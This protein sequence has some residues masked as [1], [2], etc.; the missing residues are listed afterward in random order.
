[1]QQ[2]AGAHAPF[3]EDGR[4]LDHGVD[5][6]ARVEEG[7]ALREHGQQDDAGGPDVDLARLR[8]ALEQD[9]GG[10]EAAG[11]GAVGA[12]RGPGVILGVGGHGGVLGRVRVFD[13]QA[14]PRGRLGADAV[15]SVGALALRKTEVDEHAPLAV[16]VIQEVGRLDVPVHD[17][18]P[19]HGVEGGEEGGEVGLHVPG[20]HPAEVLAE[21]LV[22]VVGEDGDD[23]VLVAEGGNEGAY[24]A[25]V[26]KVVEEL[27]LV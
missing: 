24:R 20:V 10:A 8:G 2:G 5:V 6:V 7:E 25:G 15:G 13:L 23:L 14:A 11:A 27:E 22:L 16:D 3:A 18:F 21:V 12:A 19:V 9:L 4:D 26:A 17:A 1:M